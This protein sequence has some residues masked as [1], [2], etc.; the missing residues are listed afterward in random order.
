MRVAI[1]GAGF[2]GL[3]M[4]HALR[5]AGMHDWLM[6]ERSQDVGGVWRS[7]TYPGIAC[8]VPS[9]L[10]SLSFAPNPDWER[11]FSSGR[12]IWEYTQRVARDMRHRASRPASARSCSTRRWDAARAVWMIRTTT[13]ELTADVVVDGTGVLTDP[14]Y[15]AIDG[16]D[17]FKGALFHS[18]ALESRAGPHGQARR[19]DRHRRVGDPD[20]ARSSRSRSRRLTVFQRTPGWVIPRNDR[21]VTDVE[22]RL[23]RAVPVLQ[24]LIRGGQFVYRDARDA[25]GHAPPQ[26]AA[27]RAGGV[28]GLHAP[29]RSTTRRCARSS[30]PTSRSAASAS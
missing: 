10:Y 18:A 4:V 22:R 28:E 6:V 17:R 29:R 3:A 14:V 12:Q 26:R 5:K 8:D 25:E 21:D 24:K 13:L 7:N 30:R 2:T 9:H 19:R 15:P 20:R 1:I 23:L 27:G 11:T 16:L